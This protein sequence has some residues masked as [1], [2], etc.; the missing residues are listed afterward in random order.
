MRNKVKKYWIIV[1]VTMNCSLTDVIVV[2]FLVIFLVDPE[3]LDAENLLAAGV[4]FP[5]RS[6]QNYLQFIYIV[7]EKTERTRLFAIWQTRSTSV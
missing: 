3:F 4:L 5:K 6:P 1:S 2:C 7:S